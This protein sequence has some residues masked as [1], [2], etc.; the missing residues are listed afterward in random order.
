VRIEQKVNG[1]N[2][3]YANQ[4]NNTPGANGKT[5][6]CWNGADEVPLTAYPGHP[7]CAQGLG[8]DPPG[9]TPVYVL[10]SFANVNG[11]SRY[12]QME[13][14]QDPPIVT[15][16][17]I[18]SA[19]HI[20][21]NGKLGVD[22][23]DYC[24]CKCSMS[25]GVSVC[26]NNA[27]G[28]GNGGFAPTCDPSHYAIYTANTVTQNG[29]SETLTAGTNPVEAT[30][31]PWTWD[32][33]Q[34]Y[35]KYANAPGSVNVTGPPYNWSCTGGSCGTQSNVTLGVPPQFPPT[36]AANPQTNPVN[37]NMTLQTTVVPGDLQLTSNGSVGSGILVVNGNLDIHGGLSFYGLIIVTGSVTFTGG[38]S[39]GTNIYGA[40]IAGQQSVADLDTFGGSVNIQFDYCALPGGSQTQPPRS[41][42]LRDINF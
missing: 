13:V 10:T 5:P 4:G 32:T 29:S 26:T 21:L 15:H 36:P 3:P 31:Q 16:G 14:A 33:Q 6:I 18:D 11:S 7:N 19:N 22:G 34:L 8:S 37:A 42:A 24:T 41:L 9:H 23:Y 30:N 40:I 35:N 20:T 27:L 25:N 12:L 39:T 1:S 38:G 2:A 28:M 17:A